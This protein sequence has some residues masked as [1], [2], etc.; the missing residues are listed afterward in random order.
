MTKKNIIDNLRQH[1][2]NDLYRENMKPEEIG[3]DMPLFDDDGIGLDSL[4]AVELAT[5]IEKDYGIVI[6]DDKEAKE[7]FH[8]LSS[9]ANH[10]LSSGSGQ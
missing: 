6:E 1:I 7:I 3:A 10:I 2:I 4:D 8:S 5:I 9:L